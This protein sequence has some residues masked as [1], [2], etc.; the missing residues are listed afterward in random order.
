MRMSKLKVFIK[1]LCH[2]DFLSGQRKELVLYPSSHKKPVYCSEEIDILRNY[3]EKKF[4]A[5]FYCKGRIKNFIVRYR[6]FTFLIVVIR[7]WII[8]KVS[9]SKQFLCF[10]FQLW[11]SFILQKDCSDKMDK[12]G[13]NF[14]NSN[15][16]DEHNQNIKNPNCP[17]AQKNNGFL[18][19]NYCKS[20]SEKPQKSDAPFDELSHIFPFKVEKFEKTIGL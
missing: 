18:V 14:Y 5:F 7:N 9:H 8:K 3:F 6:F 15:S 17:I 1:K 4:S 20:R 10:Y 2:S 19:K 16:H 12:I 13:Y 11:G